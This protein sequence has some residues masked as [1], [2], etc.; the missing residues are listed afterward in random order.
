MQIWMVHI[1]LL[2]SVFFIETEIRHTFIIFV[3]VSAGRK[4]LEETDFKD[5][6]LRGKLQK[7][8]F[9]E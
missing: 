4:D 1:N 8:L 7:T 5:L 3:K 6:Q 9:V 2:F